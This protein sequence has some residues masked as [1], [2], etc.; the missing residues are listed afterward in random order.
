MG[1]NMKLM[2][3]IL[4]F[5]LLPFFV[6][7]EYF[8]IE[9]YN[10][11]ISLNRDA[12][13]EVVEEIVVNFFSPRHG[14]YRTIPVE[15]QQDQISTNFDRMNFGSNVYK[16]DI[17]DVYVDGHPFVKSKEGKYLKIKIG[18]KNKKV[19][20]IQKYV[21]KYKVYG[22]INFFDDHSEFYW[23]VIGHEWD[24][25]IKRSSFVIRL[26]EDTN[27]DGN[28]LIFY[29]PYGSK[30]QIENFNYSDK[31]LTVMN[32]GRLMPREGVTVAIRFDKTYFTKNGFLRLKLFLVNNWAI[33]IPIIVL[34]VSHFLWLKYGK[35][36][37][38]IKMV[39]YFPP[40]GVTPAEAGVII[41]DKTDNRD[42]ISLIFYWATKGIIKI[43]EIKGE[44]LFAKDD[45]IL[46]KQKSLP[47]DAKSYEKILFDELFRVQDNVVVSSLKNKFH[48]TI[49]QVRNALNK[50]IEQSNIYYKESRIF[51]I[52]FIVAAI[53]S[54]FLAF[55]M[56]A[57]GGINNAVYLGVSAVILLVYSFI[58]PKKTKI[59]M[60]KYKKIVG[61]KEFIDKTEK[62]KL[63]YL[64]N[65][66]PLYFDKT[67][68]YAVA[69]NMLDKWVE[70]F[71]GILKS[72]P[73]WYISN[74]HGFY[75]RNFGRSLSHSVNA[76]A[77]NFTSAPSSAGSGGSGFSGGG[78]GGG[79]GGG[80]GG[81][82]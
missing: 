24:T 48:T 34:I 52:L 27:L 58:M 44:W 32:N 40:E 36:D 63:T 77:N 38:I 75:I 71:D 67:L 47:T 51:Q 69:F 23:N 35:D 33:F 10:V 16:I 79:F 11:S 61:F 78:S 14:I 5:L 19:S 73:E 6:Y 74:G 15:Y 31:T 62:S 82:W 76:M 9:D 65:E 4:L 68:P 60:D 81:S 66:D 30:K 64:L 56:I 1:L 25:N 7:A 42:I 59:G 29:G 8:D 55:M 49:A 18:N 70:K 17:Y 53:M 28:I 20:G 80:G 26:P 37:D 2:S 43:E 46:I 12:S 22:A 50:E 57:I 45:Y 3:Y 13:F 39:E 54:G 41:D 21:I 72:P